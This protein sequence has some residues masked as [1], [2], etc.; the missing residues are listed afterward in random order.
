LWYS[1][2]FSDILSIELSAQHPTQGFC[3][4]HLRSGFVVIGTDGTAGTVVIAVVI[5]MAIIDF[6]SGVASVLCLVGISNTC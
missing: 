6:V 1:L 4:A 3:S 2:R 5:G